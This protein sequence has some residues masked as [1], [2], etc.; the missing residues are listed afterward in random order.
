MCKFLSKSSRMSFKKMLR[1][2]HIF[3]Q[4]GFIHSQRIFYHT[5]RRIWLILPMMRRHA[6]L[7]LTTL[8]YFIYYKKYGINIEE[9]GDKPFNP[10]YIR[11]EFLDVLVRKYRSVKY[12]TFKL[13]E[14]LPSTGFLSKSK[15][16]TEIEKLIDSPL[17][18]A[19]VESFLNK[20]NVNNEDFPKMEKVV[21]FVQT[22][23]RTRGMRLW[24]FILIDLYLDHTC[25]DSFVQ[26]MIIQS[27]NKCFWDRSLNVAVVGPFKSI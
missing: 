15:L 19:F 21:D 20:S 12:T 27:K 18:K 22:K 3:H 17:I 1:H 11:F 2:T 24:Y 4:C 16:M 13:Y 5:M 9:W 7:I 10:N 25:M 14:F 26:D 8:A 6:P 23:T